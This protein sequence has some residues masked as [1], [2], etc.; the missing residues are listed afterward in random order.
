MEQWLFKAVS[1]S[2]DM[3]RTRWRRSNCCKIQNLMMSTINDGANVVKY[4]FRPSVVLIKGKD[5]IDSLFL[6]KGD[7]A[8]ILALH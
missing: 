5:E 3:R 7:F 4:L 2:R 6:Q 1:A 8:H